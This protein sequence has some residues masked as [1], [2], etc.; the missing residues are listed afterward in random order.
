[1]SQRADV[2]ELKYRRSRILNVVLAA[3][4][5]FLGLVVAA[6]LLSGPSS[7]ASEEEAEQV[8]EEYQEAA[9]VRRDADDQMAIG[10]VDAP[11]VLTYFFD[12]RCP[13]CAVFH[14][15]TLPIL[16]E[17]YV[18]TGQ[19]RIEFHD[20]VFYGEDSTNAA[21]AAR[22]A[23]EQDMYLEYMTA[24]YDDAPEGGHP[25]MPRDKLVSFA[26][27]ID[28][29]D[30]EQFTADLDDEDLLREVEISA[31]QAQQSGVTAVPFFVAGQTAVSGA[32]PVDAFRD[33]LD[34]M[35]IIATE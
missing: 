22:A 25:D 19:V 27:E 31:Q 20:V 32:Q 14:R 10:D 4:I 9:F 5:A 34:Q 21:V 16:V 3:V 2:Y 12:M 1:M 11:V 8:A 7:T 28:I 26:E 6:Q 13:F 35:H 17:E 29:P 24:V 30:V 18:D 23:G 33:F 15:D